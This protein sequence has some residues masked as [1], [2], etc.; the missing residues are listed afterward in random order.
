MNDRIR[1]LAVQ[2][3][4]PLWD[5]FVTTQKLTFE[6]IDANAH[7]TVPPDGITSFFMPPHLDYGMPVRNMEGLEVLLR[8][9]KEV[10]K[11]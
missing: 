9:K 5:L 2:Y 6:G 10:I 3:D 4:V 1:Q 11:K 8:L 7:L